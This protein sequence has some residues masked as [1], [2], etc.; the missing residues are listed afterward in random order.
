[1]IPSAFTRPS[2]FSNSEDPEHSVLNPLNAEKAWIVAFV[3]GFISPKTASLNTQRPLKRRAQRNPFSSASNAKVEAFKLQCLGSIDTRKSFPFLIASGETNAKKKPTLHKDQ[4]KPK[5][6]PET[7]LALSST[8]RQAHASILSEASAFPPSE[9]IKPTLLTHEE[10]DDPPLATVGSNKFDDPLILKDERSL[11]DPIV[12]FLE[13]G[14][15]TGIQWLKPP[16]GSR[17]VGRICGVDPQV[18]FKVDC[19]G[20][21]DTMHDRFLR[22]SELRYEIVFGKCDRLTLPR[23]TLVPVTLKGLQGS[24]LILFETFIPGE[25]RRLSGET[26][27]DFELFRQIG[28]ISVAFQYWNI[29]PKNNPFVA[30]SN[31]LV[32]RDV[33]GCKPRKDFYTPPIGY[34]CQLAKSIGFFTHLTTEQKAAVAKGT[35]AAGWKWPFRRS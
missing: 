13:S 25:E 14:D 20:F 24:S 31:K 12:K 5:K 19:L 10:F 2:I 28:Y 16:G 35:N 3:E 33:T 6:A 23:Q 8:D 15:D 17:V 18:V 21:H 30:G 22:T 11:T 29:T 1:M 26:K 9:Y 7:S 34:H 27:E 32:I 4:A